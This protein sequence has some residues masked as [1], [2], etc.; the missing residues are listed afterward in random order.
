MKQ[1]QQLT[2]FAFLLS[3]TISCSHENPNVDKEGEDQFKSLEVKGQLDKKSINYS[4]TLYVPIYSDIYMDAQNQNSLLSA[5]LSIR[6][7]SFNDSLFITV[8]DYYNT[9]GDKVKSFIE[10]TINVPPMA[11]VNYVIEKDDDTGGPG[12]NFIIVMNAKSS[13]IKP[14]VQAVMLGNL[15]NKSFAFCTDAYSISHK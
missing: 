4:D 13:E 3:L 7:T 6:N 11:T 14:L 1:I 12:A 5:T 15:G 9:T 2:I 10:N 8:I